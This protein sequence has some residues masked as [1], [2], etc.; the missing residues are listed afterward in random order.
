MDIFT[1]VVTNDETTIPDN[2]FETLVGDGKRYSDSNALAKAA[3][4]KDKHISRI[5]RENAEMRQR[6]T[7]HSTMDDILTQI[8][9]ASNVEPKPASVPQHQNVEQ[10]QNPFKPEQIESLVKNLLA[11]NEASRKAQSNKAIVQQRLEEHWGSDAQVNLNKKARELGITIN[12]LAALAD[13]NPSVF[14]KAVDI[15][16][17]R[18]ASFTPSTVVPH[19]QVQSQIPVDPS[20]K[21]AAYYEKLKATNF[22]QYNTQE[23]RAQMMADALKLGEKFFS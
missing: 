8:R 7:Q 15:P 10:T 18:Q 5:E 13:Q 17:T 23:V 3:Y 4:E 16:A 19:S 6:I 22:A 9:Q 14:F 20:V 21:N 2:P 12:Q 11:E 1:E